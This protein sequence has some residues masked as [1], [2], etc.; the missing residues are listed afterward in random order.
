MMSDESD[1]L[2]GNLPRGWNGTV[3]MRRAEGIPPLYD[4]LERKFLF[5]PKIN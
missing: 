1:L 3:S 2:Y 4:P 5:C